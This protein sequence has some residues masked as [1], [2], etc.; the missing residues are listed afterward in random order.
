M[1]SKNYVRPYRTTA[2][3]RGTSDA[4][5]LPSA[6]LAL[7]LLAGVLTVACLPQ[8]SLSAQTGSFMLFGH[9]YDIPGFGQ[10]AGD[11]INA[12]LPGGG[13]QTGAFQL[14]RVDRIDSI[15]I[16]LSHSRRADL[17]FTLTAPNGDVLTP[18]GLIS[19]DSND[20][21][22]G[23]NDLLGLADYIFTESTGPSFSFVLTDPTPAG[24]YQGD[25]WQTAPVGGWAPG[26]WTLTLRDM[27]FNHLGAVGRVEVHGALVP[28][29]SAFALLAGLAAF[30]GV[31]LRRRVR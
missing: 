5:S 2:T 12:T 24:T 15:S 31:A 11:V 27:D 6:K 17:V 25:R 23:G 20:L 29:P 16:E 9:D 8:A 7:G 28:E 22:N 13:G 14:G 26:T 21:G 19:T 4:R 18:F 30:A 10:S 1:K 3:N